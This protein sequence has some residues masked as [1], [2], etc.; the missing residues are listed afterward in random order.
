MEKRVHFCRA[1]EGKHPCRE[2]PLKRGMGFGGYLGG[3]EKRAASA[4]Q[5]FLTDTVPREKGGMKARQKANLIAQNPLLVG[6][7][8]LARRQTG[9]R[10]RE[11]S[12][13]TFSWVMGGGMK[14]T[15]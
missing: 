5:S 13:G 15:H 14:V 11:V 10:L 12:Q 1:G 6:T 4:S 7:S 8:Y 3:W 9:T 2:L